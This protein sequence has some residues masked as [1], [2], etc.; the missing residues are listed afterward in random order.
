MYQPA[1]SPEVFQPGGKMMVSQESSLLPSPLPIPAGGEARLPPVPTLEGPIQPPAEL[2]VTLRSLQE[3]TSWGGQHPQLF[4]PAYAQ[5]IVDYGRQYGVDSRFFGTFGPNAMVVRGTN[6]RE[7][8]LAGGFSPRQRVI[9]DCLAELEAARDPE[10]AKIYATEALTLPALA[11]RGRYPRFLGSEYAETEDQK[12]KLYPIPALDLLNLDLPSETF[13]VILCNE[14]LEHVPDLA[15]GVA[16]MGRVLKPGGVLLGTVPFLFSQDE[17]VV[18]AYYQN[19]R[20][21]YRGEPEYHHNPIDPR[22]SLVFQ[23]PGWDLLR[24]FT[25]AGFRD[26]AME[27]ISSHQRGITGSDPAGVI[28]FRAVK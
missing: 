15:R 17:T 19:G 7:D 23:V 21:H 16:E 13:D 8:F 20:L 1:P 10:A 5:S 4:N 9:L 27:F 24:T 22:G 11:L 12:R 18:K 25:R 3:W 2:R 6:Y 26:A 28:L 14:V